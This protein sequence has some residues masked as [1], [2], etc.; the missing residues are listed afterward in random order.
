MMRPR[1]LQL[2]QSVLSHVVQHA[3]RQGAGEVVGLLGGNEEGGRLVARCAVP[4]TNLAKGR[5]FIADPYEQFVG[6]QRLKRR[7]LE[8]VGI[9]HSHPGGTP[10]LSPADRVF[11]MDWNCVHLVVASQEVGRRLW[12]TGAWLTD[13]G[14]LHPI[15]VEVMADR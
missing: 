7:G 14:A 5:V 6:I 12:R 10:I 13:S 2:P 3:E 1:Q 8:L 11:A 4:L 15:S 9:Y